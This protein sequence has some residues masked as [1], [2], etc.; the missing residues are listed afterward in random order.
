MT[1]MK[2]ALGHTNARGLRLRLLRCAS[3]T[4]GIPT[5]D[6]SWH[7]VSSFSAYLPTPVLNS[8]LNVKSALSQ[9][10]VLRFHLTDEMSLLASGHE[11]A[12][13]YHLLMCLARLRLA[14]EVSGTSAGTSLASKR[15]FQMPEGQHHSEP[16]KQCLGV[17]LLDCHELLDV[18]C[19]SNVTS[20]NYSLFCHSLL[21]L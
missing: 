18:S 19:H 12:S 16:C 21:D 14:A 13:F 11:V 15:H 10:Q 9:L 2:M 8:D 3:V 17:L 6:S 4:A 5:Q 1:Q 7:Q 20:R